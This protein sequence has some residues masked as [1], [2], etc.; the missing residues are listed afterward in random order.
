M[1]FLRSALAGRILLQKYGI[2]YII[3]VETICKQI[4]PKY[5]QPKLIKQVASI[6]MT[7]T[8]KPARAQAFTIASNIEK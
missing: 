4:L 2:L 7:A 1:I 3:E 6:P 8:G 5:W